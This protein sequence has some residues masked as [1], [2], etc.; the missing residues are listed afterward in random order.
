M[1]KDSQI[2]DVAV[3]GGGFTGL[4]AAYELSRLGRRVIV[5]EADGEV[6]GLAGS[7]DVGGR[8]LEKFYHHWFKTDL[9]IV[10]LVRELGLEGNVRLR[11]TQTSMYFGQNFFRLSSP[12]DL[13]RFTPLSLPDRLRLGRLALRARRIRDW[14]T[15]EDRTAAEWLTSM[16]GEAAFRKVW[17]PMLK[18]KFGP[19]AE[20]VSAVWFWNKLK[21]RGGSRG[22]QGEELLAYY[23]GGF[24]SLAESIASAITRGG[25]EV[26]TGGSATD[27]LVRDGKV[28]G[29]QTESGAI[30]ADRVVS[31]Q[32]LPQ[33]AELVRPYVAAEYEATLRR[34]RFL[35][36]VCL[37]IEL[38]RSLS[39]TYWLNVADPNFPYVG[40]IE[41]TNFEPSETYGGRHIV[42]LSK[43][44]SE[45][46]PLYQMD[47]EQVLRHSVP[48]IQRM[49]PA[50]EESWILKAHVWRAR[51]S[52]P[53]VVR[54]YESMIPSV[55][56]PVEGLYLATM[57][58]I[59][60]EDR[61]TNYAVRQGRG[62]ARLIAG[63]G[64]DDR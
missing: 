25:G 6:G 47:D 37:V 3:I 48:Y 27:L 12:L 50:F 49:F 4:S 35:A 23:Q 59:Y 63:R 24:A 33:F 9:E 56:T 8:S 57:A 38:D 52:Q 46:E 19:H 41:H 31:T 58:Q 30:L 21:L 60:P 36:N 26:R 2:Y 61:G 39:D 29:V 54:H 17:A 22:K 10:Q 53:I 5:V 43:Y 40:I 51:F 18:G 1:N 15:L 42:Y 14:R 34:I 45:T 62:V 16:G 7:F 64:I 20:E 55:V 13:L 32:P 44:L 28:R 11:P